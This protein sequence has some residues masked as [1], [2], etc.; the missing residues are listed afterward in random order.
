MGKHRGQPRT[1]VD[2]RAVW[3]V[4]AYLALV[5]GLGIAGLMRYHW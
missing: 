2:W 4:S 5:L 3:V 1:D